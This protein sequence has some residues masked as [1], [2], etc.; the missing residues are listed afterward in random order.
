MPT[1]LTTAWNSPKT[2]KTPDG[3]GPVTKP[4]RCSCGGMFPLD[5]HPETGEKC[6]SKCYME[7]K[8]AAVAE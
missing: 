3:R 2:F 6:C 5:T 4:K 8:R 7:A 1:R